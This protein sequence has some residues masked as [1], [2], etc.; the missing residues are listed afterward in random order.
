VPPF[1]SFWGEVVFLFGSLLVDYFMLFIVFFVVIF[2]GVYG[3]FLFFG[4]GHGGG[5][6]DG[7]VGCVF[8]REYLLLF[9]HLFFCGWFVVFM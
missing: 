5:F 3:V 9:F 6:F 7:F 8:V 4:V 2:S 1:L